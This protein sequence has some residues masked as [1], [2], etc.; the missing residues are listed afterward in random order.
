[1]PCAG[2]CGV[3]AASRSGNG[4]KPHRR[5]QLGVLPGAER[6]GTLDSIEEVLILF[7]LIS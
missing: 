5:T 4:V 3:A 6:P 1:M 7:V 2:E